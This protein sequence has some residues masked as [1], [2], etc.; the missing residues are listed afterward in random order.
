VCVAVLAKNINNIFVMNTQHVLGQQIF[1]CEIARAERAFVVGNIF[2]LVHF[3]AWPAR[4]LPWRG[5]L[6]RDSRPRDVQQFLHIHCEQGIVHLGDELLRG[7]Q[8][9]T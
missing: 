3:Y 5:L 7:D 1:G 9:C 2:H 8:L 6:F 4:Y